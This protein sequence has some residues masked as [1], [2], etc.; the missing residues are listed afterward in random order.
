MVY[1]HRTKIRFAH[2]DAAGIVFYPRYFELLNDAVE[3]WF[4]EHLKWEFKTMHLEDR[5]GTP[6]V[7][8]DAEFVSPGMLGDKLEISIIPLSVGTS[9]SAFAF[10]MRS[11]DAM[12]MQGSAVLVCMDLDR[13]KSRPWPDAIKRAMESDRDDGMV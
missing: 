6:T 1:I 11:R 8:I 2:V 5:I 7:K 10:S 9:S 4:T 3:D 13:Q 12:R